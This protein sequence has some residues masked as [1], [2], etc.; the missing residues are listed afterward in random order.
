MEKMYHVKIWLTDGSK[1]FSHDLSSQNM[2]N[3][4]KKSYLEWN[5]LGAWEV[6]ESETGD[7]VTKYFKI[8]AGIL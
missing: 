7:D 3:L 1:E 2:I 6:R 8:K 5:K 4:V